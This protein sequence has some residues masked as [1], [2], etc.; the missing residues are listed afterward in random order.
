[1]YRLTYRM[2]LMSPVVMASTSGD[3]NMVTTKK[4]I[5]GTSVLGMAARRFITRHHLSGK[6]IYRNEKFCR[7]F[8]E[9]HIHISNAYIVSQDEF[10][11]EYVHFPVPVSIRKEK[12]GDAV[13]DL[14]FVAEDFDEQTISLNK[15]GTLEP[16]FMLTENTLTDLKEAI[17]AEILK[18]LDEVEDQEYDSAEKFLAAIRAE[19]GEAETARYKTLFLKHGYKRSLLRTKDVSTTLNFHHA[20]DREKGIAKERFFFTY[21]SILPEQIFEGH[22]SGEEA[23]LQ[24]LTEDCGTS[25]D[26]FVGKSKNAQYGK[27]KF[28][29]LSNTPRPYHIRLESGQEVTLT[30]L[31]DTIIYNEH[32]FSTTD[33][34]SL[35]RYLKGAKIIPKKAF[36]KKGVAEAFVG[37]WRFKT[38]SERCFAAGSAFRLRISEQDIPTLSELQT[39]GIGERT[40]EGFGM[41][42][43]DWQIRKKLEERVEKPQEND[44]SERP[45]SP[46]PDTTRAILKTLAQKSFLKQTE[47]LALEDQ[48]AFENAPSM[49]SS[50]LIGRL[51]TMVKNMELSRLRDMLKSSLRKSAKDKLERCHNKK[52]TLLHFLSTEAISVVRILKQPK[53]ANLAQICQEIGF[54][55]L[56]DPALERE[57][58]RCY[59]ETF[60]AMM[61][62]RINT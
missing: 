1:M 24:R 14:L 52:K 19:I 55:H 26:G 43:F 8:L 21:E 58:S 18:Q 50:S 57:V 32:G 39:H 3:R 47:L 42:M 27:V 31:S 38:P 2:T 11:R 25:W 45:L 59:Y 5:P 30:L 48:K 54:D 12:K 56:H 15:F 7:W 35:E 17:P 49:L 34:S 62:K 13:F 28:E 33:L 61:R 20:R 29:F 46:M 36:V 60:F 10:H 16:H 4:F 53:N 44:S 23:E 51:E 22:L 37:E 9:G 41:C 40:H 6:E